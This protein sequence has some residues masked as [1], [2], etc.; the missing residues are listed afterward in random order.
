MAR[1]VRVVSR[2]ICI[3][4]NIFVVVLFLL[5][6]CNPF[7]YP[8][9]WWLI[10]LLGLMFP[11]LLFIVI[12]F[13]LCW[14]IFRSRWALLSL[15]ALILG[16]SNIRALIGFHFGT[17]FTD[18]KP[19]NSIRLLTWN[20]AWFDEQDNNKKDREPYR[21]HMLDFI[22]EQDAD[23][24]CFQEYL[25][26]ATL[27]RKANN[28]R[29]ITRLGYPYHYKV[30][31]YG[32]TDGTLS[33][34]VAIFS[35]FPIMDSL[36]IRYPGP[37]TLRAAESL[38]GI[39]IA[40]QGQRA[41]IYTTHLQSVLLRKDD[42][43]Y[44]QIIKNAEDSMLMASRSIVRKLRKGYSFRGEQADIVRKQ[45]DSCPYPEVICGDFNDVPNSYTY[46]RVKGNRQDAFR[47]KSSGIGRTF[48]HISPTLRI[49]Y[50]MADQQFEVVQYKRFFLPYSDHFPIV[51]DLRLKSR[52]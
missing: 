39:D 31:D 14:L 2:R 34:G 38:I 36:R 43:R 49:D 47:E 13:L 32:K 29:D 33:I 35:K 24:L 27:R 26:S 6:C 37:E 10:S 51:T 11:I 41:R 22:K 42:Y 28:L 15:S 4:S 48:S 21:Q 9:K 19:A 3:V 1:L 18:A 44:L 17:H 12:V 50:V 16:Y 7:L 25:E 5:A 8:E 20:V 40:I 45:L 23:V 52:E 46:F 30:Q